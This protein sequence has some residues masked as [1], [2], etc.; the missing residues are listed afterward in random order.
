MGLVISI[1]AETIFHI[2][3]LAITNSVFT[4]FIVS[5]LFIT[6]ALIFKFKKLQTI[7][8]AKSLQNV[9][10]AL[11]E[12]FLN[13]YASIVGEKRAKRYFPILTTVFF[14]ILVSSWFGL[15]PGV[16]PLGIKEIHDGEAVL[17]PLFRAPTADLNTTIALAIIAFF[18]IQTEG[19][20]ALKFN[21]IGKFINFK[22]PIFTFVGFL[23]LI[24]EFTKVISFAFRLFG[25]IFAG[26]VLLAVMSFLFPLLTSIPFLGL[27]IFV[28][29][30]QSL[31]FV[32]LMLV[33]TAGATAAHH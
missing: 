11:L 33:F 13:F 26:E 19:L 14:F 3:N 10:E 30:I 27:E 28:G 6:F 12:G 23:E 5:A 18:F 21:Y 32:M 16:G 15:L 4:T 22:N 20:K 8:G 1:A 29:V 17:V 31:V 7:P 9:T 25:N 2:G 24:G